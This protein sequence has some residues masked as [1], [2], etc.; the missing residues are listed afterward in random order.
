MARL[1]ANI[2]IGGYD[3]LGS[4]RACGGAL[5][6]VSISQD[7]QLPRM[8][9]HA[10]AAKHRHIRSMASTTASDSIPAASQPASQPSCKCYHQLGGAQFMVDPRHQHQHWLHY[11]AAT[12][13][14]QEY[15]RVC[16]SHDGIGEGVLPHRAQHIDT[17]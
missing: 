1:H 15:S 9:A 5:A 10:A 3:P 16:T 12:R 2:P 7:T 14:L 6:H 4:A 17:V 11:N 13:G 8:S